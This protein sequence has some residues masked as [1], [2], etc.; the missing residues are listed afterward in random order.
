MILQYCSDLHLEFSLNE[1]FMRKYPLQVKG[2]ILLLA[3]DIV[4]FA[5]MDKHKNFFDF[6][7]DHFEQTYWLPG[8]HEYYHSDIAERSGVVEEQIRGNVLLV[9]DTTRVHGDVQLIFSTLWSKIDMA[10]SWEIDRAMS[11]FHVIKNN[12]QRFSIDD[13]NRL[14]DT[15]LAFVKASVAEHKGHKRVV[16]THHI[17]TYMHYPARFVGD[18]VSQA[19]ATE[20]S[21]FIEP[22]GVDAWIYGHHHAN[23]PEFMIGS[24]RMLTNQL[25]YVKHG[26]NSLYERD[27]VLRLSEL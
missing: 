9:N 5:Q 21:G 11:D 3:G 23:T 19:F 4:P 2:D 22:S 27:R 12:G 14:H 25:G 26:E 24:T 13:F 18:P 8:N 10:Y 17:P 6:V 1:K 7:A 15:A 20:L 16:V